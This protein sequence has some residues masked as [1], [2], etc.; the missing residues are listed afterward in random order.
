MGSFP[1][2]D[3]VLVVAESIERRGFLAQDQVSLAAESDPRS[4][5]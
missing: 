3:E 5:G 1:L 2:H 4:R